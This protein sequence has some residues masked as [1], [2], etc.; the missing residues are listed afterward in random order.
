MPGT[1]RKTAQQERISR[2]LRDDQLHRF[3]LRTGKPSAEGNMLR[4][5]LKRNAREQAL[6]NVTVEPRG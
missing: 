4:A 2:G 6:R 3:I 1:I 5:A